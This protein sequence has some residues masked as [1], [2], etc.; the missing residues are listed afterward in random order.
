MRRSLVFSTAPPGQPPAP[1]ASAGPDGGPASEPP[2]VD[3][4]Q[5]AVRYLTQIAELARQTDVRA[6]GALARA[7]ADTIVDGRAVLVAGNGGSASTAAHV[8]C[9]LIGTCLSAGLPTARI[10][11]LSDNAGVVTALANDIGF[12]QVFSRQVRLLGTP[13]DLLLLFSVSGESPNLIRAAREAQARG[14]RVAVAVGR[15]GAKLLRYADTAV[16]LGTTDYGLAE[17]LQLA[18]NH[19]IARLLNGGSPQTCRF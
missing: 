6:V 4:V 15:T 13:G 17:D 14:L 11:G 3:A 10:V 8:V 7:V 1:L 19:I 18:L 2:G 16:C 9:D 12:E 5:V